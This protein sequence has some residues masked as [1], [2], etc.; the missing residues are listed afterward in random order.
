MEFNQCEL[1]FVIFSQCGAIF[2][3]VT[4][5]YVFDIAQV[6]NLRTMNMPANHS[7]HPALA[8]ELNHGVLVVRDVFHGGLGFQFDVRS[9]RPITETES[10]PR[11]INPDVHVEDAVVK[12]GADTVEQAVEMGEAVELMAV[13]DQV[14]LSIS[15]G[16]DDTFSQMN[17]TEAHAEKFFQE[18]VVVSCDV[19]DAGLFA[20]FAQQFLD[21]HVVLLGPI[22]FAAQ[23]PAI[24]EITNEVKVLAFGVAEE[25]EELAHLSVLSAKMNVGDPDGAIARRTGRTA[26]QVC[27]HAR[28]FTGYSQVI[29][30][31]ADS[32]R[33]FNFCHKIAMKP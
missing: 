17:S 9:K 8:R 28:L 20:V 19:G 7:S 6:P 14:A 30:S 1:T 18:L 23:L 33:S 22:P 29:N 32:T 31:K 12:R 4:G 27:H 26:I 10:A 15:G 3:P 5:V 21:E 11:A 24:D 13:N 2:N 16:M 25:I